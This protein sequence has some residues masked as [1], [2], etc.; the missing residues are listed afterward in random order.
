[1]VFRVGAFDRQ[2][3]G[4]LRRFCPIQAVNRLTD[5]DPTE[6]AHR[7]IKLILLDIDNTLMPWRTEDIPQT[8]LDWIQKAKAAGMQLC[9]LSNTHRV[10]RLGR[11]TTKMGIEFIR[12]K[13][14]PSPTM[15]LMALERYHCKAEEALMVGDQ[16]FTDVWGANR[17]G[18][19]AIWVKPMANREFFGTKISRCGERFIR[20]LLYRAMI[21]ES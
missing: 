5:I 13:F 19:D 12:D 16:L 17:A 3:L 8:T 10:E 7:G 9:V 4:F 2:K 18:I 1:M 20:P 6:L 21:E 14:K 15:Y 11:V